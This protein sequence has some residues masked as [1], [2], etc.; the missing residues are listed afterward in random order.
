MFT[1][2]IGGLR[3]AKEL[4]D[5]PSAASACQVLHRIAVLKVLDLKIPLHS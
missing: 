4:G 1:A 5:E 2:A 3:H